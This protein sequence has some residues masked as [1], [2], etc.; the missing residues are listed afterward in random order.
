MIGWLIVIV[1]LLVVLFPIAVSSLTR[2]SIARVSHLEDFSGGPWHNFTDTGNA[3][4]SYVHNTFSIVPH[5]GHNLLFLTRGSSTY[6]AKIHSISGGKVDD[7]AS[8]YYFP[9]K[10]Y[11]TLSFGPNL[12]VLRLYQP[13]CGIVEAR[14]NNEPAMT[15]YSR[16][17]SAEKYPSVDL[18]F[19][20][21]LISR[22][23]AMDNDSTAESKAE[24]FSIASGVGPAGPIRTAHP[25]AMPS[26]GRWF[27]HVI[28]STA[29]AAPPCTPMRYMNEI[30][31]SQHK[32]KSTVAGNT[33]VHDVTEEAIVGN[34]HRFVTA[35]ELFVVRNL[36]P[37]V[38]EVSSNSMSPIKYYRDM[39]LARANT[40]RLD[41]RGVAENFTSA[42]GGLLNAHS[43]GDHDTVVFPQKLNTTEMPFSQSY[44]SC[45]PPI[46]P[47]VPKIGSASA[48]TTRE[49]STLS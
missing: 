7:R 27:Q 16:V 4:P 2:A 28:Q 30:T 3:H 32:I 15:F 40:L 45:R 38:I 17:S 33:T 29:C 37:N 5:R 39:N 44:V 19:R 31:I 12:D 43:F 20:G 49:I 23:H 10:T 13:S 14:I 22:I 35:S 41:A 26:Y 1:L 6:V 46:L 47:L 42:A 8:P 21:G 24:S 48:V 9:T 25:S 18:M 36:T 34:D 11:L